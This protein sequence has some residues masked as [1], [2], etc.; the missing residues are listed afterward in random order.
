MP[1]LS[2][3]LILVPSGVPEWNYCCLTHCTSFRLYCFVFSVHPYAASYIITRMT[4]QCTLLPLCSLCSIL[5]YLMLWL[6]CS[7]QHYKPNDLYMQH[8]I[9]LP[10]WPLCNILHDYPY[11]PYATSY[12]YPDV[13]QLLLWPL[14]IL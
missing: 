9:L 7:T 8:P 3:L 12:Y 11:D 14:C 6:L 4:L 10:T 13:E 1:S 5:Q 2:G